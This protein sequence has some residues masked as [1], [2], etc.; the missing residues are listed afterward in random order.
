[1]GLRVRLLFEELLKMAISV[2][3]EGEGSPYYRVWIELLNMAISVGSE[4]KGIIWR[5]I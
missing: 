1:M 5:V 4:G 2:G 3:S